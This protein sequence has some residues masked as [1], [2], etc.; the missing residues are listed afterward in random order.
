IKENLVEALTNTLKHSKATEFS[1]TVTV[2]N[3]II[4]AE[5]RDNGGGS[6]S[7]KKSTGLTAIEERTVL[8]GGKCVFLME[9]SYFAIINIF[10]NQEKL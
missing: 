9:P 6:G 8:A 2:M 3:K 10:G 7:I 5:L 1:L 4:R